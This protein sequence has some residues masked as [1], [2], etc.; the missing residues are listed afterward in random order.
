MPHASADTSRVQCGQAGDAAGVQGSGC[1]ADQHTFASLIDA[2]A[3]AGRADMAI[4]V[5]HKAL[6]ERCDAALL[7]Y[8]SAIASCRAAKPVDLGTAM[9]IYGDM[10]RWAATKPACKML[11]SCARQA[12][13]YCAK[14]IRRLIARSGSWPT[15]LVALCCPVLLS[16]AKWGQDDC[17]RLMTCHLSMLD[18]AC[19][20]AQPFH[21]LCHRG[22]L[23]RQSVGYPAGMACKQ[24]SAC[25]LR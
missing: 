18:W 3:R 14:I 24:M 1:K 10:Q 8:A 6:R 12:L 13:P 9:D 25:M 19:G 22:P 4:R 20:Q 2:C 23:T 7:V 11:P 5:Y 21:L 15:P 16:C 17:Q